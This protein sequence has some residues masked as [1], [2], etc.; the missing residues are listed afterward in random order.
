[1]HDGAHRWVVEP[2]EAG[3]PE[4]RGRF[5]LGQGLSSLE[6]LPSGWQQ[7]AHP[8]GVRAGLTG[9]CNCSG[10]GGPGRC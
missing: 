6:S 9:V 3:Q 7:A 5:R 4:G 8:L 2:Q 10:R 1:M